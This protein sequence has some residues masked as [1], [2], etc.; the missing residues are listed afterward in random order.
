[1]ITVPREVCVDLDQGLNKEWLVS[2]GIGGYASGTV[3]GVNTRRYHGL[4]VASLKPPVERTV[5]LS[6]IDE[7]VEI[8]GRTYYLGAN[9][10]RDGKIHPGGFV[11]IDQFCLTEGIPTTIFRLGDSLLHK[12]VWMERGHNTSYVRYTYS[13]GREGMGECCLT[14]HPMCNYREYHAMTHGAFDWN[15]GVEPLPGGAKITAYEG[16]TPFWLA[17]DPVA[18]FTHTGVWYWNFIYR[19]EIERGFDETEDLYLPGVIRAVLQ[20]GD[21][22]T[23]VASTEPP[24]ATTPLLDGALEREQSRQAKLLK[25]AGI[26]PTVEAEDPTDPIASDKAFVGQL[27]RAADQFMVTRD[28]EQDGVTKPVP[29]VLAGYHWFSDWGRDTMVALP[30]LSLPT[31]RSGEANK[32]LHTFAL[33]ARDGLIPNN[34]PDA[35]GPPHYN[36]ADATLWMF[37]AV[38]AIA[39]GT[40][41]MTTARNLYPLL[42]DLIAWHVRG[43]RFGIGMDPADGLLRAGMEAETDANKGVGVQV[44]WM[45]AKVDDWVIT[46]RTGK[47][48]EIN[49]LWYNALRVMDKLRVSLG[50]TVVAGRE[51]P[52]DF[53]ALAEQ[54][55]NSFRRRFWHDAEGYLFDVI[56][57]PDGNDPSIRPNQLL[58]VSLN[59]ELVTIDQARGVLAVVREH[60]STPYGLRTLSPQDPRYRGR[61]VGD[62][63]ERDAAYHN[64]TVWAWL[65]GPY[66]DAVRVVEGEEAART[67]LNAILPAL[68]KHLGDAG[69]GTISEI[70]DGDAPHEP[71]GCIAQA[72]SVAEVLRHVNYEL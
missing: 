18:E 62:R 44:T 70:F 43:T 3:M 4:L 49:A 32:I 29:T 41:N 63:R 46:P 30:G 19:R 56:D 64:G 28:L 42:A 10:Y 11:H 40:G 33:F 22:F 37:A 20:P 54:A 12:T 24:E 48:V 15:F 1:M 21:S 59:R 38:D 27:V 71:R 16:A 36:T 55:R 23:L 50:R 17:T 26:A 58:A 65:L 67:E 34:F 61:Y 5:L 39:E 6:N 68:C 8:D 57:G 53:N 9:E 13:E 72:W 31:K 52:P 66:L 51:E 25:A 2:N 35:G 60:L 7:E 14:L 47:P 69:L 45:D